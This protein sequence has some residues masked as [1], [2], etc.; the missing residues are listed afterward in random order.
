VE[1]LLAERPDLREQVEFERSLR[2]QLRALPAP[3][4]RPGFEGR[5]KGTLYASRRR[6]RAS[7]LLPLAAMLSIAAYLRGAPGFVAFEVARDHAHCFGKD[8]LP[9]KVW[10]DHPAEIGAWFE[11]QGTRMP[12][13]PAG[14]GHLAIVGGRYCFLGDR[15][16]AHVYYAGRRGQ[17]SLYVLPGPV[18]FD[19]DHAAEV[20]GQTVRFLHTAGVN[21]A[22][23]AD[24]KEAV[25]AFAREFAQS[26]ARA[27]AAAAPDLALLLR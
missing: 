26:V 12:A 16:G 24:S 23:V 1:A 13:L 7:F 8:D 18:R 10:S 27:E 15:Y 21:L 25:D 4:P 9:A 3:E 22:L 2:E 5:V 14:V 11:K 17:L 19:G 6:R 20:R